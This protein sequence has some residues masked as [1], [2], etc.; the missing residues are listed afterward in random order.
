MGNLTYVW[1]VFKLI[2]TKDLNMLR[3]T[4]LFL[5]R[6]SNR[7]LAIA[8]LIYFQLS[9]LVLNR[10]DEKV[11]KPYMD[12]IFHIPQAQQYCVGNYSEVNTNL[13]Q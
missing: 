8:S 12:E 9:W 1:V 13:M 7:I 2:I 10:I 3:T 6:M 4:I 5:F 11:Y